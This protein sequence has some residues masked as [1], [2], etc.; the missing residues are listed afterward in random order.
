MRRG[1]FSISIA[2]A[3]VVVASGTARAQVSDSWLGT[4][5]LNVAK[6]TY[7]P[8]SLAP[9]SETSK[10]TRSGDSVTA[11]TDVTDAQGKAIHT[12]I[13]YKFDGAEYDI[14]GAPDARS[15]RFYTRIGDNT[16][17]YVNK[18]NGNITT[19]VHVQVSADGKTR[20]IVTTGRDAQGN[21]ID[22]LT[23]WEKQ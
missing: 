2:F 13:T 19:T 4:W 15:T 1:S 23:S 20:T 21:V 3:L 14:K 10:Q 11:V 6:S 17:Q 9:R 7:E 5:K 16:Y 22:N 18:V 12:E 8:A